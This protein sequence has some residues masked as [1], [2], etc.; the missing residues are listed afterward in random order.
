MVLNHSAYCNSGIVKSSPS[1]LLIYPL[2]TDG[3]FLTSSS[4]VPLAWY[5][6]TSRLVV[7]LLRYGH[8]GGGML[9]SL[10]ALH[11]IIALDTPEKI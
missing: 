10:V 8:F 7:S 1:V 6:S 3:N 5:F 9:N 11:E 4:P 2:N